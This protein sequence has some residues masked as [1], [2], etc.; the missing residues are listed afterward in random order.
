[1]FLVCL[2]EHFERSIIPP[3]RPVYKSKMERRTIVLLRFCPQLSQ[4]RPGFLLLPRHRIGISERCERSPIVVRKLG[5]LLKF[6]DSFTIAPLLPIGR[7]KY[8]VCI[9]RVAADLEGLQTLLDLLA[10]P[11]R[12]VI[13]HCQVSANPRPN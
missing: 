7:A 5:C 10:V 2:S 1:M 6:N 12:P 4:D 9:E 8:K 13:S 11:P 3:Q